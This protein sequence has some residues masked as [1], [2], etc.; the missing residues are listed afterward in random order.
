MC[1]FLFLLSEYA[2]TNEIGLACINQRARTDHASLR[3]YVQPAPFP[4]GPRP[5]LSHLLPSSTLLNFPA[6][7]PALLL[8]LF[9][10]L[11]ICF[12]LLDSL[13]LVCILLAARE[14]GGELA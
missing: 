5:P 7:R 1:P 2:H 6:L 12:Y 3:S 4:A 14:A 11:F 8:P 9:F 10:P 13:P